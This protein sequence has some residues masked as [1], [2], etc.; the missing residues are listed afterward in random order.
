MLRYR[1]AF[2]LIEILIVI[3]VIG[4]LA[5]VVFVFLGNTRYKARDTKRKF[6]IGQVGKFLF[7]GNCYV[8]TAGFGEYDLTEIMD[9]L[10]ITYPQAQILPNIKDPKTGIETESM[11]RYQVIASD[12]CIVYAN[13]E[14]EEE[15]VTLPGLG[16]P[17]AGKG[18]GVLVGTDLGVNGTNIY[19]QYGK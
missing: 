14:N 13:L 19:Y 16:A 18:S 9:E 17:E 5:S 11:Y 3:A 7:L 4:L 8:P 2:S 6:D 10:K 1:P 12:K 15:P